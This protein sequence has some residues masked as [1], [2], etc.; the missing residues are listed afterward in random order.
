MDKN[1][2]STEDAENYH[3]FHVERDGYYTVSPIDHLLQNYD[4]AY[5]EYSDDKVFLLDVKQAYE[6]Y[7]NF[8]DYLAAEPTEKAVKHV[9][10][11]SGTIY[12]Y[13]HEWSYFLR[14]PSNHMNGS[15]EVRTVRQRSDSTETFNIYEDQA[16]DYSGIRPAFYLDTNK[17]YVLSGSGSASDPYVL[18]DGIL[19]D[20]NSDSVVD[21]KDSTLILQHISGVTTIEGESLSLGDVNK[22]KTIDAKDASLILQYVVGTS[23]KS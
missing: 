5:C 13:V 23:K 2:Y 22:D 17:A 15:N 6:L 14:T 12:A 21:A 8:G 19:G 11:N 18:Y 16:Y 4:S 10:E 3:I 1:E 20:V 9:R 7:K